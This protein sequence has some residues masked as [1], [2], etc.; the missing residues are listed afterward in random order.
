MT[1]ENT[2]NR[3]LVLLA[4]AA[5]NICLGT[6]LYAFSVY[7]KPLMQ[8]LD[9]A[10]SQVALAFSICTLVI[11]LAMIIAGKFQDT[12]GP[13]KVIFVGGIIF[14]TAIFL[15]GFVTSLP[16][17]Y[18]TYGV[19]GGIGIGSIYACTVANTVKFFPDKRGLASGLVVA[20]FASGAM[21]SVYL[22]QWLLQHYPVQD[23]FRM[24]GVA[25]LVLITLCVT[26]VRT[27]PAGY[28]PPGWTPPAPAAGGAAPA[29]V[30][31]N[32]REML[33][34]PLFYVL[35]TVYT[36]G[37][38]SGLMFMVLAKPIALDV[39]KATEIM[40]ATAV[41]ILAAAN[42]SGRL[43]W[44]WVSDKLG[45]FT[46]L[47]LMFAVTALAMLGMTQVTSYGLYIVVLISVVLCFGGVMGCFP[48]ITAEAFGSKNL[49]MNYGIIFFAYGV[50]GTVGPQ[51]ASRIK[52]ASGG[53]YTNAFI[54][55]GCLALVGL[56]LSYVAMNMTRKRLKPAA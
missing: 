9:A 18:L 4:C 31:K 7:V 42:T 25:Y 48:S 19:L 10:T 35:F 30:D 56:A 12:I 23:I 29:S 45:R 37:C 43:F 15:T 54:I 17:L 36:I 44:G 33:S 16:M 11:P 5:I 39:A 3:W 34:D 6:A 1:S 22:V 32:W 24:F 40:A 14:G 51:L 28:A 27:A 53:D 2:H 8:I 52:E 50:G 41:F 38:I 47:Y 46:V 26:Q 21:F 20:G 13:K 55:A 49:G